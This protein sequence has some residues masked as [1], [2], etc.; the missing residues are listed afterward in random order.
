MFIDLRLNFQ[1]DDICLS[2][3]FVIC[4]SECRVATPRKKRQNM[5]VDLNLLDIPRVM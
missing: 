3:F 2:G 4:Q 1:S 5:S